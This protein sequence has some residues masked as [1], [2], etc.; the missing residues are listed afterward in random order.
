M[1]VT[2]LGRFSIGPG[3][4]I[5]PGGGWSCGIYQSFG[6]DS[7]RESSM[8]PKVAT[9]PATRYKKEIKSRSRETPFF[10]TGRAR[11]S[12]AQAR[13]ARVIEIKWGCSSDWPCTMKSFAR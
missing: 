8:G 5:A 1:R 13:E 10:K 3:P 11:R 7:L 4:S 6:R 2:S 12:C 9:L